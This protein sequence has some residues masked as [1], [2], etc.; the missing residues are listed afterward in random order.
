MKTTNLIKKYNNKI[1]E[2]DYKL[3][4]YSGLSSSKK[5]TLEDLNAI[6]FVM[7][8]LYIKE[9]NIYKEIIKDLQLIS[10]QP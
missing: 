2:L 6:E 9:Q 4:G 5:Q 8:D 10:M 7:I 1:K 3:G